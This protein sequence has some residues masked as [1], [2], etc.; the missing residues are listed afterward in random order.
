MLMECSLLP[1][2]FWMTC[3]RAASLSWWSG[4]RWDEHGVSS[5]RTWLGWGKMLFERWGFGFL[6]CWDSTI[7]VLCSLLMGESCSLLRGALASSTTF[8]SLGKSRTC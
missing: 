6:F 3:S 2:E 4:G 8:L 7:A 1:G 5:A